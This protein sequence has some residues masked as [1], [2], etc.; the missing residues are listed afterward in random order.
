MSD[1]STPL[2]SIVTV[3]YNAIA[4]LDNTLKSVINQSYPNIEY[5]IIDGGSTDGTLDLLDKYKEFIARV[6]SESDN[7]I[8]DAMN[9]GQKF[10]QGDWLIFLG[11]DDL[12]LSPTIIEEVVPYFKNR[13][14]IYYG[15]A[16]IKTS[17]RLYNGKLNKWSMTLGSVSHQAIFYPKSVYKNKDY[18]QSFKIFAD[19]IYNI[20]LF[21]SHTSKFVYIPK[22]IS[23]FD[24]HGVS[25]YA[26]DEKYDENL[27]KI[28]TQHFGVLVGLYVWIRRKIYSLQRD[29][30]K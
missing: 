11:A 16:Y 13:D 9:K 23:I 28:I 2:V 15:N 4:T 22:L 8:F 14:E 18:D 17:N 24:G 29:Y 10:A 20:E 12:L 6:V 21:K 3:V 25:S 19:H 7:G 27:V 30:K 26:K 5:I 1:T